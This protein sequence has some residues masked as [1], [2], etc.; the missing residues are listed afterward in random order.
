M[1]VISRTRTTDKRF[2]GV[3]QGTV[4][5]VND[6]D[7]KQGRVKVRFDWFDDQMETEW[8]RV[9][10]FYAG[11]GYGAFFIP[12]VDD[13]VLVA[14]MHGDM[15]IPIILGG[16]YNGVDKPVTYRSASQDQKL[17]RTKG[18]HELLFDD[19]S[20]K[21][22]VRVKTN[23]GHTADLSDTDQKVTVQ[24]SGGQ[25]VVID[26][27]ARTITVKTNGGTITL[28]TGAGTVTIDATGNISLTGTNVTL[29]ALNVA[30][31]GSAAAHPLVWG[32]ILLA[33]LNS[34]VHLTTPPFTPAV[35]LPPTAL[36]LISKT[37]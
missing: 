27:S 16:L 30:L 29:E 25:S 36:S 14:F 24:S 12:E 21:Q 22:R 35:P 4:T 11:N 1:N 7:G 17:I 20:G 26:D 32:D 31:G 2:Y 9:M 13:E 6:T 23:G 8:C 5:D 28:Q 18:Q 3:V 15:R 33:W 34:H 37:V 10:Q 19:T